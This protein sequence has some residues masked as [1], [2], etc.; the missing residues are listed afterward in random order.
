MPQLWIINHYAVPPSGAGGTRHYHLAR[1]LLANGWKATIIASATDHATGIDRLSKGQKRKLAQHEGINFL[2]LQTPKYEG[3][4]SGRMRNMLT[5]AFRTLLLCRRPGNM[6]QP[7]LIIGSTVHPFSALSGWL[8]AKRYRVPF[9]FEIRDLWPETLIRMKRLKANSLQAR[10]LYAIEKFLTKRAARVIA[11]LPGTPEYLQSRKIKT[12]KIIYLPNG[13]EIDMVDRLAQQHKMDPP[14]KDFTFMY[15]GA[16]GNANDLH[17]MIRGFSCFQ[18]NNPEK[19]VKFRMIG[20][21]PLK[22][23]IQALAEQLK[24]KNISFEPA[25]IKNQVPA[26][27]RTAD[28]FLITVCNLPELYRYGISMNKLFDYMTAGKPII[29]ANCA[30]NDPVQEANAGISV[31]S[32][33]VQ[34]LA[35]AMEKIFNM[36]EEERE[37]MGNNGRNFVKEKHDYKIL[38]QRLAEVLNSIV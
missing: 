27:A 20:E 36:P 2:W 26:M 23:E 5:F 11:L 4:D 8:L 3:N 25:V 12:D 33:D 19:N 22:K 18:K 34:A 21:G 16:F 28:A 6:T 15:F 29:I 31:P 1:N 35:K 13:S 10:I 32:G 37:R 38:A 30:S 17:T 24:L 7:D 9:V 14:Y